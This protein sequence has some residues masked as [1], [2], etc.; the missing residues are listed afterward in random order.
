MGGVPR[1]VHSLQFLLQFLFLPLLSFAFPAFFDTIRKDRRKVLI[2]KKAVIFVI[3]Q[4]FLL[5]ELLVVLKVVANSDI[6][7]YVG[8]GVLTLG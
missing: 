1:Q 3:F 4:L 5:E 8:K 7:L 2:Q 6:P